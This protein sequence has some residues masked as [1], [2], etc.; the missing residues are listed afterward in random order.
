MENRPI[1]SRIVPPDAVL[2]AI[3]GRP[4]ILVHEQYA[5]THHR[6]FKALSP[7]IP[8]WATVISSWARL[9]DVVCIGHIILL[10]RLNDSICQQGARP[11]ANLLLL[12]P[13]LRQVTTGPT[14][15]PGLGATIS[16]IFF[17]VIY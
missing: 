14:A 16:D 10:R 12:I 5:H 9:I 13:S 6:E 7:P 3:E 1:G 8:Y 15:D 17:F 2:L 11:E 4:A